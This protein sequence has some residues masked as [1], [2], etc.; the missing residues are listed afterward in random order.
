MEIVSDNKGRAEFI[1][2]IINGFGISSRII[3]RKKYSVVYLKDG[4]MI[5]EML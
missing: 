2:D 1:Q 5:V 3:Q 4:E